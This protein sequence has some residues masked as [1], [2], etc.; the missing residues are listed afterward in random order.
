M[1]IIII[2]STVPKNVGM[3][4]FIMLLLIGSAFWLIVFLQRNSEANILTNTAATNA[5]NA[6]VNWKPRKTNKIPTTSLIN[7]EIIVI[8]LLEQNLC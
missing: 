1:F 5:P 8:K 4:Y 2:G 3:M 6:P 7:G